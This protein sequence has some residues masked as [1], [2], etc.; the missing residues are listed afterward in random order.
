MAEYWIEVSQENPAL[1]EA[2]TR[3]VVETTGGFL[4]DRGVIPAGFLA[5]RFEATSGAAETARRLAS[6]RRVLQMWPRKAG[7]D[8]VEQFHREG[9]QGASASFRLVGRGGRAAVP[10][11]IGAMARAYVNGGGTIEL[12]D[13]V[14][15][16]WMAE[17]NAGW[18]VG[19]EVGE[20]DRRSFAHRRMPRLPFQRPVSLP[21][22]LGR[23]A[24]NL[25]HLR[26]GMQVA[27][28][29]V[30]TGALLAE[31][32]LLGAR[33]MGVDREAVMVRGASANFAHL[34]LSA[35]RWIVDDAGSAA[36]E[37]PRGSL[38]AIVTDPPYGRASS[39]GKEPLSEL[40]A[41]TLPAWAEAVIPDGRIVLIVAGG[42]DP[43][44]LPWR[45]E[46]SVPD[47]V[48]RS[49]TREFR[50]YRRST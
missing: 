4:V 3:A 19:E 27:D 16:F 41:R 40:L 7:E 45:R 47:R 1:A 28:P 5:A 13:P 30:G 9:G 50:V 22:R 33:V 46:L 49:L 38:D 29:F 18:R 2:E 8:L 36:R 31:A 15:R 23:I 10:P 34:G 42:P 37:F 35:E 43:L 17:A 32:A 26:P 12:D 39:A 21:P 24:V 44:P 11:V 6:A 20:V 25:A 14:R 48:H